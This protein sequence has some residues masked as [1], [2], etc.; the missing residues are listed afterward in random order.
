M[1]IKLYVY[2]PRFGD[3]LAEQLDKSVIA[4]IKFGSE[5]EMGMVVMFGKP[6]LYLSDRTTV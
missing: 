5:Y 2:S 4:C 1:F 6:M 3:I